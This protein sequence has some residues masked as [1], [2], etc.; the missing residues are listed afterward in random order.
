MLL[1]ATSRRL[2][3]TILT[4]VLLALA[5]AQ[6]LG[7]VH[8]IVHSPLSAHA[9]AAGAP[10][11]PAAATFLQALFAGHGTERGCDLYDQLSH[12]DLLETAALVVAV[13]LAP[14]A[15]P[16][17]PPVGRPVAEAAG[18]LARGPPPAG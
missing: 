6:T 3:S 13:P 15:C 5:L 10:P 17:V 8:R 1:R 12:S 18:F 16:G 2:R 7:V 4:I 14:Q 11:S 9:A